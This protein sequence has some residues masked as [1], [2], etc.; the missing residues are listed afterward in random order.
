MHQ[1]ENMTVVLQMS[2]NMFEKYYTQGSVSFCFAHAPQAQDEQL[3]EMILVAVVLWH[4]LISI[5]AMI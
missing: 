2:L 3:M 1:K 4:I 5:V